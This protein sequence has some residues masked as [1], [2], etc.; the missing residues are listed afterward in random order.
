MPQ[1]QH[2]EKMWEKSHLVM[3]IFQL[4]E[5]NVTVKA[6]TAATIKAKYVAQPV[7]K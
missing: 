5:K 7:R 3:D 1:S 4:Q 6:L 2:N